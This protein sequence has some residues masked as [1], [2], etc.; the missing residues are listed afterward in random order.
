MEF[1]LTILPLSYLQELPVRN[2]IDVMHV[3]KNVAEN[4]LR[5]LFGEKDGPKVR[6]DLEQRNIRPHLWVRRE[7]RQN[8]R[9]FLPAAPYVLSKEQRR[10][11]LE[12]LKKLKL[13]SHFSSNMHTKISK[14]KLIGLKS[15]DFHV[16]IQDLM[17][18]C[19]RSCGCDHLAMVVVRVSRLFKRI[20]SKKVDCAEREALFEECAETLC[21]LEKEMPPAFFDI[22]VH[23]CIHV[24]QELFICGPIHVR[25]MYP[26]ERY[27]K[28][29]KGYVRNHAKP[30]G[31]MA[32]GYE[33]SEACGFATEYIGQNQSSVKR[34]WDSEEDPV[35]TDVMLEGKGKD[36]VLE[37]VLL[38]QMHDF[39]LDN[40]DIVEPYR[41]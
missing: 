6:A 1:S 13:P 20:C 32:K 40:V 19:M 26:F 27:Y 16:L 2:L 31:C 23:L 15:H 36:R 37:E 28:T 25:W 33:V 38:E 22:M 34:V 11:F 41:G 14:G 8:P 18:L 3:E 35:M 12:T 17:P 30:E 10:I 24:V 21:V 7:V 29:L 9:A 4:L 5:T 39:V